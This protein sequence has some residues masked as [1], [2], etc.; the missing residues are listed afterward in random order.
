MRNVI[1]GHKLRIK[2]SQFAMNI[3]EVDATCNPVH[4]VTQVSYYLI[5]YYRTL[6]IFLPFCKVKPTPL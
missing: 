2:R 4:F 1:V 3:E 6:Y 5:K